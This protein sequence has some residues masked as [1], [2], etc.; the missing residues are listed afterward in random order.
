MSALTAVDMEAGDMELNFGRTFKKVQQQQVDIEDMSYE[1][2][3]EGDENDNK[4]Q[5]LPVGITEEDLKNDANEQ[6]SDE[7]ASDSEEE[8]MRRLNNL[9]SGINNAMKMKKA[10]DTGNDKKK[11]AKEAKKK[12]LID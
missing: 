1:D 8:A 9:E 7:M 4:K 10:Y 11:T 2:L 3:S 12:G 5:A 6:K